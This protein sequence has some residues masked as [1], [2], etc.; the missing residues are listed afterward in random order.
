MRL[1][2]I[3]KEIGRKIVGLNGMIPDFLPIYGEVEVDVTALKKEELG[4]N[5]RE[6][7]KET[8]L[9]TKLKSNNNRLTASQ[10]F[11]H[12]FTREGLNTYT[13][14]PAYIVDCILRRSLV[15]SPSYLKPEYQNL[16]VE[17]RTLT[18]EQFLEGM[19][20]VRD[21]GYGGTY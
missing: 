6:L 2:K 9:A 1:K 5:F 13:F 3:T 21:T 12:E 17:E 16:S 8:D 4:R 20:L 18:P 7:M 14:S 11:P 10:F 15:V 19:K